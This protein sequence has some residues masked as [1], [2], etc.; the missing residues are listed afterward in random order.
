MVGVRETGRKIYRQS[1]V[2]SASE[3]VEG[4]KAIEPRM[5]D[6]Q[7]RLL[8]E[9]CQVPDR[10][11]T[12]PQLAKLVGVGSWH[13][14]N[15]QYGRLGHMFCDATGYETDKREGGGYRWWAVWSLGYPTESG[16]VWE[17]YSEVAEALEILGWVDSGEHKIPEEVPDSG[18]LVEGIRREITVNSFERNRQARRQCIAYYG[19]DCAVCE[20]DL[21]K[22]YGNIAGGF[23]H[24]H[25]IKPLSEIGKAYKVHPI[26]DLRPVCPN[27][28]A[29]IHLGSGTR[30]IEEVR[31]LLEEASS[32]SV[33]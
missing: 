1:R 10:A 6:L 13:P 9:Q 23:I 28:H 17:M 3:Y 2:P 12:A 21:E 26:E 7:R 4:L 25:H 15:L 22:I 11:V 27:C 29:I 18:Q 16:F 24:V 20:I 5:S 30:S 14:V 33:T 19:T 32:R 31:E 8:M